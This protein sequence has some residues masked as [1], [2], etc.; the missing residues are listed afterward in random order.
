[1]TDVVVEAGADVDAI[2]VAEDDDVVVVIA[3]DATYYLRAGSLITNRPYP[4]F[5]DAPTPMY[6]P[7]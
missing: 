2:A 1:M 6:F 5:R 7:A 4:I 3:E